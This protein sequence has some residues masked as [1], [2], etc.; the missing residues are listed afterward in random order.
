M[1]IETLANAAALYSNYL[2]SDFFRGK[3]NGGRK[4]NLLYFLC[5]CQV[6][7]AI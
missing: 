5:F 7:I 6:F 1:K 4:V 3:L 2:V